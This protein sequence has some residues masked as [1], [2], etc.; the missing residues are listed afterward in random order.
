MQKTQVQVSA[1]TC[2]SQTVC[3]SNPRRS[4]A[5]FWPYQAHMMYAYTPACKTLTP[6][7]WNKQTLGR[8]YLKGLHVAALAYK[9]RGEVYFPFWKMFPIHSCFCSFFCWLLIPVFLLCWAFNNFS[10]PSHLTKKWL[11]SMGSRERRENTC[12]LAFPLALWGA[13]VLEFLGCGVLAIEY[14]TSHISSC[15]W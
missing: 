12:S 11:C 10:S 9:V 14:I 1:P 15:T 4:S 8:L 7:Q 5:L 13:Y 2:S 3:N 6:I